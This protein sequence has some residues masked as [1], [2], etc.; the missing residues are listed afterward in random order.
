MNITYKYVFY[1]DN[2]DN[3]S[4]ISHRSFSS[5]NLELENQYMM[6]TMSPTRRN[7]T[8]HTNDQITTVTGS[9]SV[10]SA[11]A[12]YNSNPVRRNSSLYNMDPLAS[13]GNT[14]GG[15][16]SSTTAPTP[17]VRSLLSIQREQSTSDLHTG[18]TNIIIYILFIYY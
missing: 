16:V 6:S 8:M 15:G 12:N 7:S 18:I 11:T 4:I 9:P 17:G 5:N 10:N 1:I 13:S 14:V 2:D 3:L